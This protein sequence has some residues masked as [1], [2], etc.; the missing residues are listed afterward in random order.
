MQK[1]ILCYGDSNTW[2]FVPGAADYKTMYRERYPRHERWPGLL[3]EYLGNDFYVV[4]EGLNGRTT[5]LDYPIPPDRNGKTYLPPCLYSHSPID[6]VILALGGNDL[7][8]YY[9]RTAEEI[10][11]GLK[12]LVT[13]IQSTN[14]GVNMKAPPQI[15]ILS[16]S[17]PLAHAEDFVDDDGIYVLKDGI[18]RAKLLTDLYAKLAKEKNCYFLNISEDVLPSEIDG[19][20][21]DKIGHNRLANKVKHKIIEIFAGSDSQ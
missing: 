9:N 1:T 19:V 14:Y 7:K 17:I 6:L 4:E 13:I 10:S 3:Q 11:A 12:E 18:R 8:A 20:H 2:G 21:L 5:N 16:L 15:L